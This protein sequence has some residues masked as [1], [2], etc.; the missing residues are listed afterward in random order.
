MTYLENAVKMILAELPKAPCR[1]A[2]TM[3][4]ELVDLFKS[5]DEGVYRIIA[6]MSALL[7]VADLQIYAGQSG[8]LSVNSVLPAHYPAIASAN[9]LA[10]ASYVTDRLGDGLFID[11]GST[12]TDIILLAQ[13]RVRAEGWTDYQRL[14]SGELIYTGIVR[15]AVMA[16]AQEALFKGCRVG[17]MAEYFA[18]MADVYRLTGELVE[19]HDQSE[20]ADGGA[21]TVNASARRLSRMIG[22]EYDAAMLDDWK[23]FAG[24]LRGQQL[25]KIQQGCERQ[26]SRAQR[27]LRHPFIGAGVG[28]FLVKQLAA[29]L[30]CDYVDFNE[31]LPLACAESAMTSA[32]CAP[33]IAV[34]LLA[35]DGMQQFS[36]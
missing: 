2:L 18:T 20:T 36:I 4:G 10:S 13:G 31:L 3:T 21:K 11:I 5:R 34:A 14:V 35:R 33:A 15:T 7:P 25:H 32:D 28:R 24:N 9:W 6:S 22:Y 23:L 16:V 19:I 17:L 8:F 1:H 29:N 27:I 30:G 12:T 26:L